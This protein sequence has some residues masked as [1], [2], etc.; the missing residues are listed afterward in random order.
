MKPKPYTK[1]YRFEIAVHEIGH[2]LAAQMLGF[3][4][5]YLWVARY[6]N[7]RQRKNKK[8]KVD[9]LDGLTHIIF[10]GCKACSYPMHLVEAA[11]SAAEAV[12]LGAYRI[13]SGDFHTSK[14]TV[15]IFKQRV[16]IIAAFLRK[17]RADIR[18]AANSLVDKPKSIMT[19]KELFRILGI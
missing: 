13:S 16:K 2:A 11:G 8:G 9:A 12:V 15:K 18:L 14:C 6:E 19:G 4:V 17:Y 10:C 7:E 5:N 3:K 1:K